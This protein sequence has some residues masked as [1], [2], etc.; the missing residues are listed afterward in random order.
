[1]QLHNLL[2]YRP[3]Q[4]LALEVAQLEQSLAKEDMFAV[5]RCFFLARQSHIELIFGDLTL[6]EKEVPD[7]GHEPL[8]R[9]IHRC[10]FW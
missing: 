3:V 1:M 8:W 7:A 10:V 4:Y 6:P 2:G 9:R 5:F